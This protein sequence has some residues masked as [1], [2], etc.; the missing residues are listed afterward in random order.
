MTGP[1]HDG[2]DPVSGEAE[3]WAYS[4][5]VVAF[6]VDPG[7]ST[8][9]R[10]QRA[11]QLL[12]DGFGLA[13]RLEARCARVERTIAELASAADDAGVARRLRTLLPQLGAAQR[14]LTEIRGLIAEVR[15]HAAARSAP[16]A[17]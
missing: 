6:A 3:L 14:Q 9:S 10:E 8:R 2:R 5:R 11:G 12:A 16:T 13:L 7:R 17:I 1:A 4:R 15:A